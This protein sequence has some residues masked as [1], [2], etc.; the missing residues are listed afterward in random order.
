MVGMEIIILF[1]F[2][3]GL[4]YFLKRICTMKGLALVLGLFAIICLTNNGKYN[5]DLGVMKFQSSEDQIEE[6]IDDMFADTSSF[7]GWPPQGANHLL[8]EQRRDVLLKQ[9]NAET[10]RD[11]DRA[12]SDTLAPV[13]PEPVKFHSKNRLRNGDLLIVKRKVF[14]NNERDGNRYIFYFYG[15]NSI[16]EV[17]ALMKKELGLDNKFKMIRYK[18][19]DKYTWIEV[20]SRFVVL[21]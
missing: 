9:K 12:E 18:R 5:I 4:Y 1:L 11:L 8:A 16:G 20:R 17:L 2:I 21:D 15:T 6:G 7:Q 19:G 14:G 13:D 10:F 3:Y